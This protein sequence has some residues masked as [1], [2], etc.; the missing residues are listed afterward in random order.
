MQF[1]VV[2]MVI[3]ISIY[4][5]RVKLPTFPCNKHKTQREGN[6]FP[7]QQMLILKLHR[8]HNATCVRLC[9]YFRIMN[10]M[11]QVGE[12]SVIFQV[13]FAISAFFF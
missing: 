11:V 12:F 6:C 4:H 7:K 2:F 13:F 3:Y 1:Q 8:I 5:I 10:C 9:I